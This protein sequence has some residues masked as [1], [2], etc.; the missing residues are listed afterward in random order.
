MDLE[1]LHFAHGKLGESCKLLMDEERGLPHAVKMID[2]AWNLARQGQLTGKRSILLAAYSK[3]TDELLKADEFAR[4]IEESKELAT[5]MY[6]KSTKLPETKTK[7]KIE[8]KRLQHQFEQLI[9]CFDD[10]QKM[11]SRETRRLELLRDYI[12]AVQSQ[13]TDATM[14]RLSRIGLIIAAVG[15]PAAIV[16]I[17]A[18]FGLAP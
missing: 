17:L 13:F 18:A 2:A 9:N 3:F 15:V 1:S 12:L 7:Q 10:A 14:V 8:V 6:S 11:L 5:E 4:V 16:T